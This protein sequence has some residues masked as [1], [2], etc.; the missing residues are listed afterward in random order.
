[1]KTLEESVAIVEALVKKYD[2]PGYQYCTPSN[3][4]SREDMLDHFIR[5]NSLNVLLYKYNC[6]YRVVGALKHGGEF[7][8]IVYNEFLEEPPL[9][10]EFLNAH[11]MRNELYNFNK[12]QNHHLNIRECLEGCIDELKQHKDLFNIEK[13]IKYC[14][15]N[16]P[17]EASPDTLISR[18]LE[19]HHSQIPGSLTMII[20]IYLADRM[21]QDTMDAI[22]LSLDDGIV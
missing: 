8:K 17:L 13:D 14:N 19:S 2:A 5:V 15:E 16:V 7:Y 10:M 12:I 3:F 22:A 20:Y 1:M 11:L 21:Y 4:K 18:Y 6:V 9:N